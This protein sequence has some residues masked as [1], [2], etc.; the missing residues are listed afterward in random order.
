MYSGTRFCGARLVRFWYPNPKKLGALNPECRPER[1]IQVAAAL[2]SR[3]AAKRR[4]PLELACH[5]N[6]AFSPER[7]LTICAFDAAPKLYDVAL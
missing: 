7:S 6:A 4:L 3:R 2:T 1:T 5:E